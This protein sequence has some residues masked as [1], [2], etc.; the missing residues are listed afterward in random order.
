[1]AEGQG[2]RRINTFLAPE[3][4]GGAYWRGAYLRG[5]LN[6]KFTIGGSF[7]M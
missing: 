4:G 3:G 1:M 6:R 5:K 7:Y 2:G